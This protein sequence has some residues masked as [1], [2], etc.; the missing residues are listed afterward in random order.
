MNSR[1]PPYKKNWELSI[2]EYAIVDKNLNEHLNTKYWFRGFAGFSAGGIQ[3]EVGA[4]DM[5]MIS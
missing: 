4:F 1:H 2:T 3:S 5:K